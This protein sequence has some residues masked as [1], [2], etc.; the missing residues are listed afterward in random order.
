MFRHKRGEVYLEH[1]PL[2]HLH[3]AAAGQGL[4]QN[5]QKRP[6]QLHGHHPAGQPAQADRQRPDP[7]ADFQHAAGLVAARGCRDPLRHPALNEKVL[8]QALGKPE[9]V[10]AQQGLDLPLVAK[11]HARP[12]SVYQTKKP[13]SEAA[14]GRPP[15]GGRP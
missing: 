10:A 8:P 6:V 4:G 14:K 7:R 12:P 15:K 1:I 2:H 13:L 5:R 9:A 11:I 3:V